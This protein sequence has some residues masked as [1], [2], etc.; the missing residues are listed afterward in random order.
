M[1]SRRHVA[2]CSRGA[3]LAVVASG[4][5]TATTEPSPSRPSAASSVV[6][7]FDLAAFDQQ[8]F[9]AGAANTEGAVVQVDGKVV[10]ERYAAGY[11]ATNR[12]LT[13]SVSKSV[14][15]ALIGIAVEQGVLALAD[16]ACRYV[17][18]PSGA[19]PTLCETTVLDLLQM[20][21]G[22]K[23]DES[24]DD[25]TVSNVLPMLYGNEPDMGLYVASRPREW[26]A[27][28]K[29][30]YSSGDSNLLA[31]ALRGAL[32]DKDMR[33]WATEHLFAPVGLTSALVESDRAGTLVL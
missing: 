7:P 30:R 25:P 31:R 32:G 22:L 6:S 10:Y 29:W 11:D 9:G 2:R 24:Y 20:T 28:S 18:P 4:C 17:P 19:D 12:H 27:G 3:L 8:L 16:S 33:A 21:S 15:S 26:K 13:Y 23:W 5:S 1:L 14:G